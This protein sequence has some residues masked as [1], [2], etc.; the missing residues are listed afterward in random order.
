MIKKLL[1]AGILTVLIFILMVFLGTF[2]H[3]DKVPIDQKQ[4]EMKIYA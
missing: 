3:P 2:F 1:I 4:L